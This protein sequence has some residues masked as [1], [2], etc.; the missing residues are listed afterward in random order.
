MKH[1]QR[2]IPHAIK[3]VEEAGIANAQGKVATEFNG[4]VSSFGASIISSGLLPTAIFY[5]QK[6]NA[7][8]DRANIVKA[9]EYVIQKDTEN[10]SF[11]LLES[12]KDLYTSK[13]VN[14]Q[15]VRRLSTQ[16]ENSLVA[17]KLAI[18]IFEPI[19][20]SKE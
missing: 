12:V 11:D 18:R 3:A 17:I 4:Y 9:I 13:P 5:S 1:I 19:K 10:D 16:V 7:N 20:K 8:E 2:L 15:A 14:Q 6:K